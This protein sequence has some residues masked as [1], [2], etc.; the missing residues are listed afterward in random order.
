MISAIIVAA[1]KGM[2]MKNSLR[3]QYL[4]LAGRPVL[5]HTLLVIDACSLIENIILVVPKDDF[6]YCN[7]N[8]LSPITLKNNVTLIPGGAE[9]QDS[10]YNGLMAVDSK[11][12]NIIVIHD[13]VRPLVSSEQ[14]TACIIGAKEYGACILGIPVDS[15]LKQVD[16]SGY[17]D[18]TI[19]RDPIWLAQTPQAFQYSLLIK[20][21]DKARQE[22]FS[23]TD[24]ALLVE[25]LGVNVKV[26]SGSKHNIKITTREDLELAKAI[27]ETAPAL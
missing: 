25:R 9:R 8:V 27:L 2:R 22:D 18:K 6:D 10:V 16:N 13:G 19:E 21:H 11:S 15:T 23:G 1:G 7:E 4:L 3:K 12:A 20:A 24:D 26:I 17:V 14:L 5:A